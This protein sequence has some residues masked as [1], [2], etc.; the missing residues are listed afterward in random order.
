MRV[1]AGIDGQLLVVH[2]GTDADTER[3]RSSMTNGAAQLSSWCLRAY[4]PTCLRAY[5]RTCVRAYLSTC[6]T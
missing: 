2:G 3:P 1:A 5:V 4:V 6:L